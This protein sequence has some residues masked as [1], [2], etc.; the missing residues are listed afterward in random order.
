MNPPPSALAAARARTLSAVTAL[1]EGWVEFRGGEYRA[2]VSL[3]GER[4]ELT[5]SGQRTVQRATV[6][7][8]KLDLDERPRRGELLRVDGRAYEVELVS[9]DNEGDPHWGVVAI[10]VPGGDR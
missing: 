3:E 9:G 5:D 2:A 7:F 10:R 6:Q 4:Y 8:A 1:R